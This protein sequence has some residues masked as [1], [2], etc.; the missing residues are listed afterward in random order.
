M[1]SAIQPYAPRP[2]LGRYGSR[3]IVA[4][5][6]APGAGKTAVT[7]PLAGLLPGHAVLDWDAF[8]D[9]AGALA[10]RPI[11]NSPRTWPAYRDLVRGVLAPRLVVLLGVCT[12]GELSDWPIS[13][14][15]YLDSADPGTPPASRLS[16]RPGDIDGAIADTHHSRA[17]GLPIIDT[18]SRTPAQVAAALALFAGGA[19]PAD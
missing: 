8:M 12:P 10:E 4:V 6:S 19:E 16:G 17:L 14:W 3:V 15:V 9:P 7:G 2:R 1:S 18:T 11:R 5:L 13:A